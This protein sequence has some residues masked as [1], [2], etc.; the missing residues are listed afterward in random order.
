[1][2]ANTDGL[3]F[4]KRGAGVENFC[5]Q[6]AK[7]SLQGLFALARKPLTPEQFDIN[8]VKL[9]SAHSWALVQK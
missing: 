8:L 1:M 6:S 3:K 7:G 9:L 5:S 2:S 4:L